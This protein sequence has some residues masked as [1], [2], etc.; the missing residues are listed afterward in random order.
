[1]SMGAERTFNR[2]EH[3]FIIN[4]ASKLVREGNFLNLEKGIYQKSTVN[5]L[6]GERKLSP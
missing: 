1:M 4:V 5:I 2:F 3:S 6:N